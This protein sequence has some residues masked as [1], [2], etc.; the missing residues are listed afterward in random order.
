MKEAVRQL[1]AQWGF[2]AI[3]KTYHMKLRLDVY[4]PT[5][6]YAD[7]TSVIDAVQDAL[8]RAG[9]IEDDSCIEPVGCKRYKDK[10]WPRIEA[11][12]RREW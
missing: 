9:V 5:A 12:L 2:A 7:C 11:T 10:D 6:R 1:E 8:E 3:P 4:F